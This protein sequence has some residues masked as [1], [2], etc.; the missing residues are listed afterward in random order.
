MNGSYADALTRGVNSDNKQHTLFQVESKLASDVRKKCAHSISSVYHRLKYYL[1]G[2]QE[3]MERL[4]VQLEYDEG[5]AD[6]YFKNRE[7]QHKVEKQIDSISSLRSGLLLPRDVANLRDLGGMLFEQTTDRREFFLFCENSVGSNLP[8]LSNTPPLVDAQNTPI[9]LYNTALMFT[10]AFEDNL[11]FENSEA[12]ASL[13]FEVYNPSSFSNEHWFVPFQE[14]ASR[15]PLFL[16]LYTDESTFVLNARAE[17][18]LRN[19]LFLEL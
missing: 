15:N 4:E 6:V 18:A 16:E 14:L 19:P 17:L 1:E 10:P 11:D 5:L 9:E 13:V 12:G 8:R 2:L 3:E 7:E